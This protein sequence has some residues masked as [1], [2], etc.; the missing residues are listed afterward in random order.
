MQQRIDGGVARQT[1]IYRKDIV[2]LFETAAGGSA[3]VGYGTC[4]VVEAESDRRSGPP[5][6]QAGIRPD[7]TAVSQSAA[8][9]AGIWQATPVPPSPQ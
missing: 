9:F 3:E 6:P 1:P 8:A 7:G 4:R 5:P 2:P